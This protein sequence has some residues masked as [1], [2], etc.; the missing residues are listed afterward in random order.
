MIR[1]PPRSTLFPYTTL[2]R[3]DIL[4]SDLRCPF[5]KAEVPRRNRYGSLKVSGLYAFLETWTD[6]NPLL[7]KGNLE[8]LGLTEKTGLTQK[9]E[10]VHKIAPTTSVR[11]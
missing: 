8:H 11:R 4:I 7:I 3:S 2:F 9:L 6:Y 5:L 10:K 1:R